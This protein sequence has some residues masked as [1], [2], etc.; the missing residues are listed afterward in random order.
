[1]TQHL[2]T[3]KPWVWDPRRGHIRK[4]NGGTIVPIVYHNVDGE[5]IVRAVN[6]HNELVEALKGIVKM[7][8]EGKLV[9]DTYEDGQFMSFVERSKELITKLTNANLAI[10]KAE[11]RCSH[12]VDLDARDA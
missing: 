6:A 2:E 5:L 3:V 4:L 9:R 1:M 11:A 7:I 8:D 12:T 10:A